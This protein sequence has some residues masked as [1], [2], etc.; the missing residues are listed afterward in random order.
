MATE[1]GLNSVGSAG[2]HPVDKSGDNKPPI[3]YCIMKHVS[4]M[5]QTIGVILGPSKSG[6][7]RRPLRLSR[8]PRR[9]SGRFAGAYVTDIGCER[10]GCW[11]HGFAGAM[12]VLGG[13]MRGFR[14]SDQQN[15]G[16]SVCGSGEGFLG[17]RMCWFCRSDGEFLKADEGLRRCGC[18]L[19]PSPNW[20]RPRMTFP[21][22]ARDAAWTIS[23]RGLGPPLKP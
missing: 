20:R 6:W 8:P 13:E 14:A 11:S 9:R 15:F 3:V 23:L 18:W 22:D 7:F 2:N 16:G 1:T 10:D 21:A 17:A 12:V 19:V 4:R 5:P